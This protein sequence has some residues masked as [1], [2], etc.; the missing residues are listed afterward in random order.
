VTSDTRVSANQALRGKDAVLSSAI[1]NFYALGF[2]GTSMRDIA[3]G[4]GMT[5]ASIYHHF[6]SKQEILHEIMITVMSDLM[7]STRSALM[8]ADSSPH[9]QLRAL[10]NSWIL[11]HATRQAD[12]FVAST[13]IR[14]LN[15]SGR[16]LV[17]A[18]RDEQEHMF[19]DVIANGVQDGSFKTIY[20]TEATRAVLNMGASVA[21]WYDP[22][23]SL[24]PSDLASRYVELAFGTVRDATQVRKVG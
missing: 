13:E 9:A 21:S 3:K 8:A 14:S 24:S 12:A 5:V 11:F 19:R 23:G 22:R 17:I 10:V 4:S 1:S 18:L 6:S 15:P 2:H 7:S 20:P 16:K